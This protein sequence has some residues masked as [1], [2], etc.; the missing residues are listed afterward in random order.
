MRRVV[1]ADQEEV[2]VARYRSGE[3]AKAIAASY[4]VSRSAI[5][6]VL[7][8]RGC[9]KRK[10]TPVFRNT[11]RDQEIVR[12]RAEGLFIHEVADRVGVS[13]TRVTQVLREQKREDLKGRD[14]SD[15][16]LT[17]L[18]REFLVR[19]GCTEEQYRYLQ[20]AAVAMLEEGAP[21]HA[22]PIHA[23]SAQRANA[24]ERGIGWC[25][26]IWDWWNVWQSSGKWDRRGVG[27]GRYVMGR[28]GDVGPYAVGNVSIISAIENVSTAPKNKKSDFPTGVHRRPYCVAKPFGARRTYCGLLVLNGSFETVEEAHAAYLASAPAGSD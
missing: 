2:I 8:A 26:S 25:I 4:G 22:T 23:Y 1:D 14:P 18:E 15:A 9:E 7:R 24:R 11:T 27:Y 5:D 28:H 17:K 3:S 12:L 6:R 21:R 19:N 16:R 13:R 20:G 10:I